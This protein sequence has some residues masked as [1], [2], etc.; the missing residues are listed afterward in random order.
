MGTAELTGDHSLTIH[1]HFITYGHAASEVV[2]ALIR[3]ETETLWNE[4]AAIIDIKGKKRLVIFRITA[5]CRPDIT[6]QEIIENT[7]PRHNYFRIEE[8]SKDNIS[9]VDGIGSNTGYFQLD[10]LYSGSTTAAHEYGHTLGLR[11]PADTDL[12]GKGVPGI[13]YPRGTYVDPAFQYN[14][15]ATAGDSHNGGT[16]HPRFRR[17]KTDDILQLR[18]HRLDFAGGLATIGDFTSIWH[19]NHSDIA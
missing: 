13:M 1:S 9:F 15:Q 18:L 17:V 8:F 7:D 12:R 5:A 6:Q 19:P 14:P 4:P 11:H 3:E 2:T 16:M 10:N